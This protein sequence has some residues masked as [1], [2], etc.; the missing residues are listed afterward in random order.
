MSETTYGPKS[1]ALV[2]VAPSVRRR[3]GMA[4]ANRAIGI[5]LPDKLGLG[6][7]ILLAKH[8]R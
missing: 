6:L 3:Q 7:Q 1:I 5:Q 2:F 4:L 8:K